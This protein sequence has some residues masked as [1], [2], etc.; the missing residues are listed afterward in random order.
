MI[1]IGRGADKNHGLNKP[2]H[3]GNAFDFPIDGMWLL[4]IKVLS[5]Q[6]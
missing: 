2:V 4:A 6:Q 1:K 3:D 5:K